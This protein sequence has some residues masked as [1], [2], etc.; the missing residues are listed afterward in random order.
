VSVVVF[1]GPTLRHEEAREHLDARYL[2]PVGMGDVWGLM[3]DPPRAIVIIDGVFEHLPAVWHKE[4]L[5]ALS[6]G[7]RVFGA[8]S[9]GALRAAELNSFGMEGVG[10]VFEMFR[11]GVLED[12]DEV[13]VVH[14][15]AASGFRSMSDAMI[16]MRD[17]LARA[18][19]RGVIS[20]RSRE[21]LVA[22]AKSL[23]Y[24]DRSWATLV[25]EGV[26]RAELDGVRA[27]VRTERTD[28]KR[29]DA[30]AALDH[31]RRLGGATMAPHVPSFVFESSNAWQSFL[32]RETRVDPEGVVSVA[33]LARYVRAT[34][35]ERGDILRSAVLLSAL[36]EA[37][38]I[39]GGTPPA[40]VEALEEECE[41]WWRHRARVDRYLPLELR[42]RGILE[43]TVAEARRCL[44]VS[45]APFS[46]TETE[47]AAAWYRERHGDT[48][49]S[50]DG[51]DDHARR[52]RFPSWNALIE[53]VARA[54]RAYDTD[55]G[56]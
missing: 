53:D 33:A 21:L 42:R 39:E 26:P 40:T 52:L 31:V 9:M 22:H 14:G 24:A 44:S 7:V 8:S 34:V 1:L 16:N 4:I 32:H 28:L 20:S 2:P 12:D 27:F 5:W 36:A 48:G 30:I 18:E 55:E 38:Q 3:S 10:R 37:L 15:D 47:R 50:L 11:D 45:T 46:D 6:H 54:L 13:A 51:A 25:A 35:P 17:G 49:G 29:S 41:T 56:H 19:A 43:R 23:F